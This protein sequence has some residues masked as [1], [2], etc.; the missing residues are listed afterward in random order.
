MARARASFGS[1][2]RSSA[3]SSDADAAGACATTGLTLPAAGAAEPIERTLGDAPDGGTI[4]GDGVGAGSDGDGGRAAPP[5]ADAPSMAGCRD[6]SQST[7]ITTTEIVTAVVISAP[8]C[9]D[10]HGSSWASGSV[11]LTAASTSVAR[12]SLVV[13]RG[14]G[15]GRGPSSK[16]GGSSSARALPGGVTDCD[17]RTNARAAFSSRRCARRTSAAGE[18]LIFALAGRTTIS[19]EAERVSGPTGSAA[20]TVVGGS[21]P[22]EVS[23]CVSS[24]EAASTIGVAS[25]E[26]KIASSAFADETSGFVTDRTIASP[27]PAVAVF[28]D[29]AASSELS[30][31]PGT[32]CKTTA[33]RTCSPAVTPNPGNVV[34]EPPLAGGGSPASSWTATV[35][36][37]ASAPPARAPRQSS[38][39]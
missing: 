11:S 35:P 33:E 19:P 39:R 31:A 4:A 38:D 1:A 14:G 34:G 12:T 26:L 24:N 6:V 17:G 15:S 27:S 32:A 30:S 7:P 18:C 20:A 21:A 8:R 36:R 23:A 29:A 3:S 16:G 28:P 2:F 13:A 5:D 25:S 10:G 37:R 22:G 9:R